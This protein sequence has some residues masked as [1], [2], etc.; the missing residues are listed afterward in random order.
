MTKRSSA[1]ALA[2]AA[3]SL[4]QEN[5]VTSVLARLV[6]DAA[7]FVPA[8]AAALLVRTGDGSFEVLSA[9]SH[10]VVEVELYQAQA[11]AG[12]CV[13]ACRT[14]RAT[15]GVGRAEIVSSWGDVGEAI[16]AAGFL[17]VHAF[18]M[19]WRGK[20]L[21]G[22]NLFSAHAE[23]LDATSTE[24]AQNFADFATL[25]VLQPDSLSDEVLAERMA[26]A[27]DGR[28]TIEQAKGVLA[29]RLGLDMASAYDEL[30]RIAQERRSTLG[31]AAADIVR[32]A[33]TR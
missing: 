24:L 17:A 16:V 12:P 13:D 29:Y 11:E 10:R 20:A 18:P 32:E 2:N 4:V 26:S 31:Q 33:R 9:T 15:R 3:A 30:S 23:S 8:A 19:H 14:G 28:V 1:Q 27:L 25:A 22:L 7:Q 5:D 21:G 6:R